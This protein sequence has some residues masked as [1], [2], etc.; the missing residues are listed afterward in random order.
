MQQ[1]PQSVLIIGSGV[2]GLTTAD[3]L[4]KRAGFE[5]TTITVVDDT[6]GTGRFP[7]SDSASVDSS[8]IIR[9]DYSDPAYSALAAEAQI[10]WRHQDD[11]Q[12][13]GQGRYSETGFVLT[14]ND[15]G[16]RADGQKT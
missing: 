11:H 6:F 4:S 5:N 13:G 9:A 14:A 8:R 10:H 2:F 12:L 3:A 7:P 1:S 15:T 16:K